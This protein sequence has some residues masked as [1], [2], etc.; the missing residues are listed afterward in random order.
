VRILEI[1]LL[2]LKILTYAADATKRLLFQ[3]YLQGADQ[4]QNIWNGM[5]FQAG[6]DASGNRVQIPAL[7]QAGLY[8]LP[9]Y[10][11]G[12]PA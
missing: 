12:D 2:Q 11:T 4:N 8:G 6:I 9:Q 7:N 10:Y 3:Y 5:G 1:L